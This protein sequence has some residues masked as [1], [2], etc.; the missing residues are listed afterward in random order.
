MNMFNG[1]P[2]LKIKIEQKQKILDSAAAQIYG[3]AFDLENYNLTPNYEDEQ[4]AG[5]SFPTMEIPEDDFNINTEED[6]EIPA[7]DA[8][9]DTDTEAS[10]NMDMSEG[11]DLGSG[12]LLSGGLEDIPMDE[13]ESEE[14]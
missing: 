1:D 6:E 8:D 4:L 13:G 14:A 9:I 3:I 7:D 11:G 2:D 12:D 5:E 10:N